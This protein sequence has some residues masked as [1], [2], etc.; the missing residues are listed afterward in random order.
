VLAGGRRPALNSLR[1]IYNI[2][3]T[4]SL[5]F[6]HSEESRT[7]MSRAQQG[8]KNAFFGKTHTE[9]TKAKIA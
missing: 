8:A 4:A 7:K 2:L 6:H 9:E 3:L 5:G 1:P